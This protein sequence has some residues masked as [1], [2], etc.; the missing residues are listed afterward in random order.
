MDTTLE[1]V[2][3]I[4]GSI[5]FAVASLSLLGANTMGVL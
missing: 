4:L 3:K 2:F 5:F 1:V